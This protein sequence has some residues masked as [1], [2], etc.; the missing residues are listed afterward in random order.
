[1]CIIKFFI[2]SYFIGN[3]Q[4]NR[5]HSIKTTASTLIKQHETSSHISYTYSLA[6]SIYLHTTV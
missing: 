5:D 6:L 3:R 2:H 1:M 4:Q